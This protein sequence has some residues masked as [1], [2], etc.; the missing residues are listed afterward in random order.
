[1]RMTGRLCD[2][3]VKEAEMLVRTCDNYGFAALNPVIEEKVEPAHEPLKAGS[4]GPHVLENFWRRDKEMLR[5]AD[6]VLDYDT[7]NRSDGVVQEIGYSRYCL[8][9]PTVRVWTG[10]GG[11]ISRLEDDLVAPTL[12]EAMQTILQ[13][14]GTYEKLRVW[15][16]AMW[17]RCYMPWLDEQLKMN[18]R[19]QCG[20][21]L[22]V[23]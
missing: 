6:V 8:W 16:Q 1:M 3:L 2:E 19:Y 7:Q 4:Y 18:R 14:W 22:G 21:N 20:I 23:I 12:A 11:A 9:K 10:P 5:E 15:R 17:Q 13:Q